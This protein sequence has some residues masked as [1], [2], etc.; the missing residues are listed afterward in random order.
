MTLRLHRGD[1]ELPH[2]YW[3]AEARLRPGARYRGLDPDRWYPVVLVSEP[4]PHVYY[5]L[6]IDGESVMVSSQY[7]EGRGEQAAE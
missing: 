1:G 2:L 3:P 7:L 6:A 4:E 5:W